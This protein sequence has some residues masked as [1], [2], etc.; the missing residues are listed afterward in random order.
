M[1]WRNKAFVW[2]TYE[3]MVE[4]GQLKFGEIPIPFVQSA[5]L[6]ARFRARV[7]PVYYLREHYRKLY[8]ANHRSDFFA[9]EKE[10]RDLYIDLA[11]GRVGPGQLS[12]RIGY[13]QIVW[14]ESDLYRSLDIINPLRIDQNFPIGEKFDEFR[15]PILAIKFLPESTDKQ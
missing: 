13:Q 3:D 15:L 9:P 10:F 8:D 4:N 7:D 14:G 12:S 6:S 2:L 11:H 5:A 1:Q